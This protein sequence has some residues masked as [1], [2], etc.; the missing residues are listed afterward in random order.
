M[1]QTSL[2]MDAEY[3]T[4]V[5]KPIDYIIMVFKIYNHHRV[6]VHVFK[7]WLNLKARMMQIKYRLQSLTHMLANENITYRD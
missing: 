3:R 2:V 4:N 5:T 7:L 1:R 6:A